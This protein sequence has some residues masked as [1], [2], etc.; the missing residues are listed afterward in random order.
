MRPAICC[1]R[2]L[3]IPCCS[4][5]SILALATVLKT[6]IVVEMAPRDHGARHHSDVAATLVSLCAARMQLLCH[7]AV[8]PQCGRPQMPATLALMGTSWKNHGNHSW[9]W[10][11]ES[12]S[13][14]TGRVSR[15]RLGLRCMDP[16]SLIEKH[17][18]LPPVLYASCHFIYYYC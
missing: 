12:R 1:G 5:R 18:V 16:S 10:G 3:Y 15:L 17:F 9:F 13:P 11:A 6:L 4:L 7:H 14:L 2:E 8:R